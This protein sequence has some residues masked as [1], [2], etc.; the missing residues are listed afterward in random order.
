MVR[1]VFTHSRIEILDNIACNRSKELGMVKSVFH[2][3]QS[4]T[5]EN[6]TFLPEELHVF[7]VDESDVAESIDKFN[8]MFSLRT[9]KSKEFW[10]IDVSIWTD[11]LQ[12]DQ[13]LDKIVLDFKVLP[14]DFD[15]DL[16]LFSGILRSHNFE[17]KY[18]ILF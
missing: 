16:Y 14:L 15:D 18:F 9:R 11:K 7:L 4:K 5:F 6:Q 17:Q 12:K 10:L 2:F 1:N 13:L 3:Y 8:K